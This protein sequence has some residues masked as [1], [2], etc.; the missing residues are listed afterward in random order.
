MK[1]LL[2]PMLMC[3]TLP[4]DAGETL[5][6][7][8]THS[9]VVF[10]WSHKG[11]SNPVARLEKINGRIMLDTGDLSKSSVQVV[12]PLAGLRTGVGPLDQR[13]KSDD[14][15][16]ATRYPDIMFTSTKVVQ[17]PMGTLAITGDLFVH[18]I[19]KPVVLQAKINRIEPASEA[20]RGSAGFEA[21]T[22]LRRSDFG[23]D[24][25]V[26]AISDDIHVHLTVEAVQ[27]R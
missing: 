3:A 11:L 17:G 13:L 14:F 18:G 12:M 27:T 2:F 25:Y 15:F 7:D 20:E 22:V 8:P 16:A 19:T 23:V 6:I 24:R 21:D 9:A 10:S 5:A 4:A 26:P 1:Y